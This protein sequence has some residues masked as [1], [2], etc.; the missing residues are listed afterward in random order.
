[1]RVTILFALALTACACSQ[2]R[3]IRPNDT[4]VVAQWHT[5]DGVTSWFSLIRLQIRNFRTEWT[6]ENACRDTC[7]DDGNDV[8][9]GTVNV[10]LY[11]QDVPSTVRM[12]VG[13]EN[14]GKVPGALRIG[15]A[16]YKDARRDWTYEGVYPK[17][18]KTFELM[19]RNSR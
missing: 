13:L 15:V 6:I 2:S 5:N 14:A 3:G 12:L 19:D 8:G 1:M 7:F 18:L 9:S 10:Y 16:W 11:T 4:Q 17:G